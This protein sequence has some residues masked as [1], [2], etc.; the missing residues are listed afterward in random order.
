MTHHSSTL[1]QHITRSSFNL[2]SSYF[3][4]YP[5]KFGIS[6]K[7]SQKHD[8]NLKI[9]FILK[10]HGEIPKLQS[11]PRSGTQSPTKNANGQ[12]ETVSP[13]LSN[14]GPELPHN[15]ESIVSFPLDYYFLLLYASRGE[16]FGVYKT[17][18]EKFATQFF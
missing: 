8:E 12:T 3:E 1:S 16:T 18:K 2:I 7:K 5:W 14:R 9:R 13:T 10:I 6:L 11:A 15:W 4:T 17:S